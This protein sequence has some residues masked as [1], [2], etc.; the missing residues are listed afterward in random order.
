VQERQAFANLHLHWFEHETAMKKMAAQNQQP[1]EPKVSIT[2]ALD[3]L[4]PDVQ[5]KMLAKM[6]VAADPE[7]IGQMGPHEV[8]H[9][10][11]GVNA[12]GAKE[13]IVTSLSGKSLQ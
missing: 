5:A 6:D 7:E 9:E 12:Q 13:K 2:A 8:T 1:V 3:K 4:S 10:V 11:E